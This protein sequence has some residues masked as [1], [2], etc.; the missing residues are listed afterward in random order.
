MS[1]FI[2]I[3]I[4]KIKTASQNSYHQK[5]ITHKTHIANTTP[6]TASQTTPPSS[7]TTTN[8]INKKSSS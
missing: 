5:L 7:Q 8:P 2:T 1:I 6:R 3:I 4:I